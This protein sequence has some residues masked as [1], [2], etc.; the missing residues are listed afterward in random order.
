MHSMHRIM[1]RGLGAMRNVCDGVPPADDMGI[2]GD[3]LLQKVRQWWATYVA[4]VND[5][6]M[7]LLTLWAV[8]SHLIVECYTTPRLQLDSPVPGSGK[9]TCLEHFQRL[10]LRSVQMASVSS[11]AMITTTSASMPGEE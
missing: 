6:D 9:T 8:H 10:C 7:D 2:D 4:T 11:P 5:T 3:K 1:G